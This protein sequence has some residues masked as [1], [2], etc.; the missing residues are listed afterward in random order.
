MTQLI[1]AAVKSAKRA[2]ACAL[3]VYPIDTSVPKSSSNIFVGTASAFERAG[4]KVVARRAA[5]SPDHA[6]RSEDGRAIK[7]LP[8]FALELQ[9]EAKSSFDK[10]WTFVIER[11]LQQLSDGLRV[12]NQ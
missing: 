3:E 12:G 9:W 5:A 10:L 8:R 2:R 7:I 1:A 6:P 11:H 4:F